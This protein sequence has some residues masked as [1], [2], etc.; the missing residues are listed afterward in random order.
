[1][2]AP[3]RAAPDDDATA[4]NYV[5][6]SDKAKRF[7]TYMTTLKRDGAHDAALRAELSHQSANNDTPLSESMKTKPVMLGYARRAGLTEQ[8]A[9]FIPIVIMYAGMASRCR[10]PNAKPLWCRRRHS[11]TCANTRPNLPRL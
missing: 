9:C 3:A 4:R 6:T 1:M 10:R 7:A 2:V 8:D 11:S 5:L